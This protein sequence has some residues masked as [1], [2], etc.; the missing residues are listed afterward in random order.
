MT[1]LHQVENKDKMAWVTREYT[2]AHG[3][4]FVV[5]YSDG[6]TNPGMGSFFDFEEDAIKYMNDIVK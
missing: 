1:I 3:F 6:Y 5:K 4:R 2:M